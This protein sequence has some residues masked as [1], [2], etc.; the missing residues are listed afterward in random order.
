MSTTADTSPAETASIR[1]AT[2][3][4]AEAV[5]ALL[6]QLAMTYTPD[7]EA[8]DR[9]FPLLVSHDGESL[10]LVATDAAARVRGYALTTITPLL[11][12]NGSSAQLQ[13]LVVDDE[14]RGTGIGTRLVE[15]VENAC[16]ERHVKQLLVPSRR[17]AAFYERLGY[18]S[19]ADL[20]KRTFD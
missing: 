10:L 18:R 14:L 12:T 9:A 20:L 7:R 16:R 3:E 2:L 15:S 8:F 13:E 1:P 17:S 19:T 6:Q 5:F 4:D 11:H